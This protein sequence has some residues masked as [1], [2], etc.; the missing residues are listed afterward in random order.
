[1]A[2]SPLDLALNT[3]QNLTSNW[4]RS[5]LTALGIFMGVTAINAT[6]NI[7][8]ITATI[9][10][11]KLDARDK[12]FLSPWIYEYRKP[13]IEYTDELIADLRK[14]FPEIR[15]I[16]RVS[17]LPSSQAQYQEAVAE[18]VNS[19]SVSANYQTTAGRRILQGRFFEKADFSEYRPVTVI[20]ETLAQQLFGSISP[21]G[22]GIFLDQTRL[23]VVGVS[24]SK[25]NWDQED[26]AG[27]LWVPESYGNVLRGRRQFG[28]IQIAL[29]DLQSY[30]LMQE[31]L[32]AYFEQT[33]P[34]Y[35]V[36]VGGNVEDLYKS[37][38]QLRSSVRVLKLVGLMA[39]VIGGIGI[40][41]ITIAAIME[42]TREIGL[43]R[44]IGATDLEI[45]A[46]F[47][48]EAALLSLI[49]GASAVVAVH[50][51]TKAATTT[52]FEAPYQFSIEDAAI[53]MG[54]AFVV[55]VGSSFL[56]ALR[57]TQ[58]DVVQALRGE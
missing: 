26:P 16:S 24:E 5:G 9:L 22:E 54:A 43:R 48:A 41:N 12:P 10:Q 39:L 29:T 17:W 20:D 56:P 15:S 28:S 34:D 1:M 47:I 7:D 36:Y 3:F 30:E 8:S 44:A 4:V 27:L 2:L 45:M 14:A 32:Q 57:I 19:L 31:A 40:A 52:I 23:T 55:G 6:L 51:I 33:F 46:Q 53:S 13:R 21:I 49:G 18:E 37:E 50:F 38:Q 58:I 42:R 11:Q 25:N 35:Q